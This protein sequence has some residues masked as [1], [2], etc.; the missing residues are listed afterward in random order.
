[1][2]ERE[3]TPV[4]ENLFKKNP[5]VTVTGP[6][7]SGKTTV[8]RAAFPDLAYFNLERP[9]QREFAIEDPRG[10]L[11]GCEGRAIIDEIQRAPGLFQVLR[12]IIDE[13]LL[14]GP[15]PGQFLLLGSASI[16][17]LRQG[18]ARREREEQAMT[19]RS[20]APDPGWSDVRR[21]LDA[22]IASLPDD[23]RSPLILHFLE[24]RTQ[25]EIAEQL[26]LC[27]SVRFGT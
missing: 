1:M 6:R 21:C 19:A 23:L 26:P 16:D 25:G 15:A 11:R 13:R 27:R 18:R 14:R 12:G 9:D 8:C 3:I 10:F 5:V 4:L 22:A 17:L 24:R 7:Q 2:I 20:A